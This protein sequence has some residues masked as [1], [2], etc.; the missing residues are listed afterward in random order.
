[1][2]TKLLAA[3][4][5]AVA[6]A[7]R[8]LRAGEAV[9]IPTETVYGL[10][11]DATSAAAVKK[12][13]EA[14]GR[15]QDNPLIVHIA[16]LED[17]PAVVREIPEAAQKLAQAFWPGPLTIIMKKSDAIPMATSAGL[18]TVAVRMPS[19]PVARQIIAASG[20]PLAA[21]S[22][23]LSGLPSPTTAQHTFQDM[24]GRIPL[25]V[26]GGPCEVGVESTVITVAGETPTLLRPG[27][28]TREQLQEALGRRVALSSAILNKLAEGEVAASPG[29]KYKHYSPRADV[30]MLSGAFPDYKKYVEAHAGEGVFAMCYEEEQ[31]LLGVPCIPCGHAGDPASQAHAL[32]AALREADERGARVVYAHSPAQDGVSMAV[33]NRLVRAAAFQVVQL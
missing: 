15:P 24:K 29:M 2:E 23:N 14:K 33:Y 13:F 30:V 12:I 17:L 5:E 18:D 6:E 16:R 31:P 10:A 26:D 22:A 3:G 1:M 27:Y 25:I 11:A 32:F 8:L 20:L 21:P 19:H 9:G 7:A 28:I 4:P